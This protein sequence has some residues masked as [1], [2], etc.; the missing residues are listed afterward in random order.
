MIEYSLIAAVADNLAIGKN[1]KMPW[2]VPE[3][4]KLFKRLTTGNIIIMGRSTFESVG[5]VL[6]GRTTIVV[7]RNPE[8]FISKHRAEQL[9]SAKS[10]DEALEKASEISDEA[11]EPK[12]VFIAGGASIYAQTIAGAEELYISRIPGSFEGDTFFPEFRGGGWRLEKTED[13]ESF[14]LEVYRKKQ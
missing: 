10:I 7:T 2:H 14:R 6:P 11:A 5:G 1:N 3:D 8:G 12:T 13:F 4:L 9:L